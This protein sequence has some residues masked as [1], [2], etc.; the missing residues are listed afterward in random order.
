MTLGKLA[1][2]IRLNRHGV[3]VTVFSDFGEL[4]PRVYFR[5][6]CMHGI[7]YQNGN[8]GIEQ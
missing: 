5:G 6:D 8:R 3:L 7:D 2:L 4:L 1:M